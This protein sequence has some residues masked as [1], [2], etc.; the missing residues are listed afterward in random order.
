VERFALASKNRFFVCIEAT[1]PKFDLEHTR[2]FLESL[3][4]AEVSEVES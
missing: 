2:R 1:D 3:T 4:P